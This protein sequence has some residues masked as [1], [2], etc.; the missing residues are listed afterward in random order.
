MG[1]PLTLEDNAL[2][3]PEQAAGYLGIALG[4]LYNWV[5]SGKTPHTKVGGKIRFLG[6]VLRE[7]LESQTN[8]PMDKNEPEASID[9]YP[10]EKG[11]R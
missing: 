3:T 8:W 6:K 9:K 4:T 1:V 2:Y 5:S 10:W 7:W 11:S